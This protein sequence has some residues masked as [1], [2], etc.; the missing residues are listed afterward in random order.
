M[1]EQAKAAALAWR[2]LPAEERRVYED[3]AVVLREKYALQK[4]EYEANKRPKR[5]LTAYFIFLAEKRPELSQLP[6][7]EQ[8]KQGAVLWSGLTEEQKK[9][10]VEKQEALKADYT[11]KVEEWE[12]KWKSPSSASQSVAQ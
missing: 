9:K 8:T 5:P 6:I 3:K 12:K 1:L 2:D 11:N 7:I 10:Y 4:A